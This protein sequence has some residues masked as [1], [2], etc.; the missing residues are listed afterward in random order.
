MKNK[1]PKK[2][3]KRQEKKLKYY[4]NTGS[5]D[6]AKKAKAKPKHTR[7]TEKKKLPGDINEITRG[8]D[9]PPNIGMIENNK[10]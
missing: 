3:K 8:L 6:F 1:K 7:K 4:K 10:K 9:R 5:F 2:K